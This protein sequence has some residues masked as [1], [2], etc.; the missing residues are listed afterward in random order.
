MYNIFFVGLVTIIVV[1][2][3]GLETSERSVLQAVGVFWGTVVS[4]GAFVIPRLLLANEY[5]RARQDGS[6]R[7]V[8]VSGMNHTPSPTKPSFDSFGGSR[9]VNSLEP[10]EESWKEDDVD[11]SAAFDPTEDTLGDSMME[12][13]IEAYKTSEQ[14]PTQPP[15]R[16]RVDFTGTPREIESWADYDQYS[17]PIKGRAKRLPVS[18]CGPLLMIYTTTAH[19][20]ICVV[21]K[22]GFLVLGLSNALSSWL[23]GY[24]IFSISQHH[25]P[26]TWLLTRWMKK[27][28]PILADLLLPSNWR[29]LT[30]PN[31]TCQESTTM[32]SHAK[33]RVLGV[34]EI[35]CIQNVLVDRMVCSCLGFVVQS[36]TSRVWSL[37]KVYPTTNISSQMSMSSPVL[38]MPFDRLPGNKTNSTAKFWFRSCWSC[39][40]GVVNQNMEEWQRVKVRCMSSKPL[41]LTP[42][43][44]HSL[45]LVVLRMSWIHNY[46]EVPLIC[47][48]KAPSVNSTGSSS[49]HRN[50]S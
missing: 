40:H 21:T 14:A 44:D 9:R 18:H 37:F 16:M 50:D 49:E 48:E 6:R 23:S 45:Q 24:L 35:T 4:A 32:Y 12:T 43:I 30:R 28:N 31:V 7:N 36:C 10:I 11:S 17:F 27:W 22:L 29:L 8:H 15:L 41:F 33:G 34:M 25:W 39:S 3:T 19:I 5:R 1:Q 47:S 26:S 46:Q 13:D 20:Y 42:T 38:C 2:L